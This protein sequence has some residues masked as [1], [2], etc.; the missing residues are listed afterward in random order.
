MRAIR[1]YDF[2]YVKVDDAD[3]D[4]L[5]GFNWTVTPKGYAQTK[6]RDS[7]GR[8]MNVPMHRLIMD[9]P[10][11][12]V[13]D[14]INWDTIDNR[15]CNLRVCTPGDNMKNARM[16]KDGS[17]PLFQRQLIEWRKYAEEN[18]KNYKHY[19]DLFFKNGVY[20]DFENGNAIWRNLNNFKAPGHGK[21][22]PKGRYLP[23]PFP[24]YPKR[25]KK[26]IV[27]L[28]LDTSKFNPYFPV[29]K[30][31]PEEPDVYYRRILYAGTMNKLHPQRIWDACLSGEEYGGYFWRL[32]RN[33]RT[34]LKEYTN[35]NA[36]PK[37]SM[38]TFWYAKKF[39]PNPNKYK[40]LRVVDGNI[41]NYDENNLLWVK[42]KKKEAFTEMGWLV[43]TNRPTPMT[44]IIALHERFFPELVYP[45]PSSLS[46]V[47]RH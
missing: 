10:D 8:K 38:E 13:V 26:P 42:E 41:R 34:A 6:G 35:T 45:R 32:G 27:E 30:V 20:G 25:P 21:K 9:A 47:S 5:R 19:P 12:M 43:L 24:C 22:I 16:K 4:W 28:E 39:L 14:H 36:I 29:V 40:C 7:K 23:N 33:P 31:E 18:I 17:L 37:H 15:K 44:E 2:I 11:G 1:G 46:P 3:Y